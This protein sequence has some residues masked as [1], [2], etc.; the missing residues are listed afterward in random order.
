VSVKSGVAAIADEVIGDVQKEAEAVIASAQNEAKETLRVAKEKAD[1]TYNALLS[2]ATQKSEAEKRKIASVTEVEL[3]NR[4]L[5]AKESLVDEAFAKATTA[6][7]AY[8]ETDE[9]PTHLIKLL[10]SIAERMDQPVLVVEV[11]AKDKAILTEAAL[12]NAGKA[13]KTELKLSDQTPNILGGCRVQTEDGKIVYDGTL[14]NRLE[15]LKPELR[16]QIAK[17]LFGETSQ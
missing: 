7:K 5:Q 2:E 14:D 9:Y 1:Q 13:A 17:S 3:R 6:L 12:K 10:T 15:E 4:L 11:N 16:A 8:V